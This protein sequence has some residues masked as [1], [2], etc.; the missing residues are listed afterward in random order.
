MIS[1]GQVPTD[2]YTN[3]V[4]LDKNWID[5]APSMYSLPIP[6]ACKLISNLLSS[7]MEENRPSLTLITATSL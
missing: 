2:D 1:I 7:V 5:N 4:R 6:R 3:V